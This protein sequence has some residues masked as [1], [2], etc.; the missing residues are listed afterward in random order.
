MKGILI[1]APIIVNDRFNESFH[2][3]QTIRRKLFDPFN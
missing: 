1:D 2:F 3:G